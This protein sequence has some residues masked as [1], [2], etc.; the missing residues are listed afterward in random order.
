MRSDFWFDSCGAGKI[1]CCKWMPE[2]QPK[3]VVQLVHGIAEFIERYD[4]FANYLTEQGFVVVA[5][6]HMGHGQSING[7]GIQGYFHGGWFSAVKDTYHLLSE[8]RREYP[9]LPYI[10]FG[11]SMGSFM[12]R[13]ILCQ[14]PD[15]GIAAAVICGTGWQ[16]AF[17]L[18]VL[19]KLIDGMCQKQGETVPAQKLN[20]MIFGSYNNKIRPRRTTHDWLTRD[21]AIV[22]AYIAHPL[23]GFVPSGGLLRDM[24]TGMGY[25][26]QK[27]NLAM[28]RKD[29]PVLFIA[30]EEDP[31]GSFGKGIHQAANAFRK[32][33]MTDVQVTLY[34]DCRHEILNELNREEV[35]ADVINWIDGKI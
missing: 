27:R 9:E 21:D 14:Y 11:H 31:V 23:C 10:L 12:A 32:A 26:E 16:P 22:D 1:H 19:A 3:A 20:D 7:D 2:G 5:E 17:A 18:P 34:P 33:G 28:M 35:F 8:T 13:T 24:M 25:I 6:D 4:S 15:S 30:G 29:L